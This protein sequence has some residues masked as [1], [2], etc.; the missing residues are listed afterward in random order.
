M[1]GIEFLVLIPFI[2]N[3]KLLDKASKCIYYYIIS[4]LVFAGGSSLVEHFMGNNMWFFSLMH[5]AQ[6][7]I[8]SVFYW[9]CIHNENMRT[10]IKFMP[11]LILGIFIFDFFWVEGFRAFNS[12]SSGVKHLVLLVYGLYFFLQ[13][14]RDRNLIENAIYIDSLPVFWYNSG[15]FIFSCTE[16]LFCISYNH[17]QTL[18]STGLTKIGMTMA[19]LSINY[20]VGIISMILLYIGFSKIKKMKHANY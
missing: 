12:I 7:V 9:R 1:T 19:I 3:Y 10:V 16:F 2:L 14:L 8:L 18:Q 4:S 6:F 20:I 15:I 17:L 5:F 11:V 13:M